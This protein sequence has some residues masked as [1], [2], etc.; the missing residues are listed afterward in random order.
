MHDEMLDPLAHVEDRLV[1]E[2]GH[3][4]EPGDRRNLRHRAGGDDES[5][6]ANQH[7]PGLDRELVEEVRLSLDHAHAQA[8]HA[9]DGVVRRDRGDD[10][11]HMVMH[12]AMV[13]LRLDDVDAE[14]GGGAHGV[15]A[16]AGG[17]QRLGGDAAIIETVPAHAPLLDEHHGY[18]ELGRRRRDGQTP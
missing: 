11:M 4:V 2:I 3:L 8:G 16:L 6:R 1:G 14:I 10:A 7:A 9:L 5:P 12:A 15:G 17:E 18:A 13:D